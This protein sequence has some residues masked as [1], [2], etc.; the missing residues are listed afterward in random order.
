MRRAWTRTVGRRG[1]ARRLALAL[2]LCVPAAAT[3]AV[4]HAIA[5]PA[6]HAVVVVTPDLVDDRYTTMLEQHVMIEGLWREYGAVFVGISNGRRPEVVGGAPPAGLDLSRFGGDGFEVLLV[7]FSGRV[8]H[9][10]QGVVPRAVLL[11]KLDGA[12]G[13]SPATAAAPSGASETD[14]GRALPAP[15]DVAALPL[16]RT[17]GRT[18][19]TEPSRGVPETPTTASAAPAVAQVVRPTADETAVASAGLPVPLMRRVSAA[20]A[21]A[22]DWG[23]PDEPGLDERATASLPPEGVATSPAPR[24]V[25][26][27][28]A[29]VPARAPHRGGHVPERGP[30]LTAETERP[31]APLQI[32]SLDG[33]AATLPALDALPAAVP[34]S[35]LARARDAALDHHLSRARA[36]D[37]FEAGVLDA[38]LP[39]EQRVALRF[40][41]LAVD[42]AFQALRIEPL[43]LVTHSCGAN[44][45]SVRARGSG[46]GMF[47]GMFG[48]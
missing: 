38:E 5:R 37:G 41:R 19:A 23:D 42:P 43:L 16:P 11:A 17:R 34:E 3:V 18:V 4:P 47:A 32:A 40:E 15:A 48:G 8:L 14:G 24:V 21:P 26:P 36:H 13:G 22:L 28:S 30:R 10:A 29:T 1:A 44:V 46:G 6:T 9:R 33:R 2:A 35:T 39:L 31:R 45:D 25:G 7:D 27:R 12:E 20:P